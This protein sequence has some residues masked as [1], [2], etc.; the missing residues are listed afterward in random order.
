VHSEVPQN[1]VEFAIFVFSIPIFLPLDSKAQ[2]AYQQE[3]RKQL[4]PA[5]SWCNNVTIATHFCLTVNK[6][7]KLHATQVTAMCGIGVAQKR[8]DALAQ[9]KSFP[10]KFKFLLAC[11][12]VT[13]GE[14]PR[15]RREFDEIIKS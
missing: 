8:I 9:R 7:L 4:N 5:C 13:T 11:Q 1:L 12:R 10:V 14:M 2:L 6:S 3:R 15:L